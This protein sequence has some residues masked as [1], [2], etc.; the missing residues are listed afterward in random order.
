MARSIT[1]KLP[2]AQPKCWRVA[3]RRIGMGQQIFAPIW[4][5]ESKAR[6]A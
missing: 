6:I 5:L 4:R 3:D 2:E 1:G